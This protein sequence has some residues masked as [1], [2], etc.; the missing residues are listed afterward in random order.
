MVVN[1]IDVKQ[2]IILELL[3]QHRSGLTGLELIE[4]SKG[5]LQH[6][7]IYV[8]L[9]NLEDNN[10]VMGTPEV[11]TQGELPRRKYSLTTKGINVMYHNNAHVN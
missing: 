5:K 4:K 1:F 7:T 9:S 6:G 3:Y 11:S 10:L 2:N 8:W